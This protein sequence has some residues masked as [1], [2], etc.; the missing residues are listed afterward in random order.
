MSDF[1]R[2]AALIGKHAVALTLTTLGALGEISRLLFQRVPIPRAVDLA[3]ILS[4]VVWGGYVAYRDK[5]PPELPNP[6]GPTPQ[7]IFYS[8]LSTLPRHL[9]MAEVVVG[10]EAKDTLRFS[11]EELDAI[12]QWMESLCPESVPSRTDRSF[13]RRQ[14][15]VNTVLRWHCQ[16]DPPGPVV[17]IDAVLDVVRAGRGSAASLPD[18]WACWTRAR[19][20]ALQLS[21]VL[22]SHPARVALALQPYPSEKGPIIDVDFGDLPKPNPT[23][24]AGNVPPWQEVFDPC[25]EKTLAELPTIA[26]RRLL[27][28]Y[29]Y[30]NIDATLRELASPS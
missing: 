25:D 27:R 6:V 23:G 21:E 8:Q 26:T 11:E 29:G 28:H 16:A 19:D 30:R 1:L 10:Y 24:A 20:A 15:E 12:D 4:G 5:P 22:G 18:L 3:L 17:S 2:Y 9:P 7:S 13:I 14:H